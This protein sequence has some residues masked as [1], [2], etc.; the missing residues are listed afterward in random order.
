MADV[1]TKEI[2][3]EDGRKAE[4]RVREESDCDSGQGTKV[5]ELWAEAKVDKHLVKRVV[6]H[7]RPV[8]H[9]RE[10]ETLDEETGEVINV[11]VES[12]DPDVKMHLLSR[13]TAEDVSGQTVDSDG[14][15]ECHITRE[16]LRDLLVSVVGAGHVTHAAP[17]VSVQAI[18]QDR[19]EQSEEKGLKSLDKVLLAA[20]AVIVGVLAYLVFFV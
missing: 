12:V 7:T 2:V 3:L 6:E 13:I 14:D 4:R 1:R 10:T 20:A 9:R 17:Q 15:C 11:D 19:V 5:T 16:E 18:V 8:V